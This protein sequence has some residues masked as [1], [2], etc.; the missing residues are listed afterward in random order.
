MRPRIQ[1]ALVILGSLI[2]LIALIALLQYFDLGAY[3]LRFL[4]MV[5][6][7]GVIGELVFSIVLALAVVL[8]LPGIV[9]TMGAGF[10]FGV[11][12]GSILVIVAETVGATIA[13]L[14]ARY[15]LGRSASR[16]LI[17]HP[18]LLHVSNVLLNGDW[19]VIALLRMIP[20]FPFKLSNYV[21]GLAP[22]SLNHYIIGT[23][24]GLWPITLFNVYLGSIAHDFMALSDVA[25]PRTPLQWVF[26]AAGFGASLLAVFYLTRRAQR[27]LS[28]YDKAP[29]N[30]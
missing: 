4:S 23:F 1:S 12:H 6:D 11:A 17:S 3:I 8:L 2:L 24:L 7:A 21:L 5:Q 26:Y 13:F 30:G 25:T 18:K 29:T 22:V 9:F 14:L 15:V 10:L 16:Y 28:A 19:R 27:A 20:F